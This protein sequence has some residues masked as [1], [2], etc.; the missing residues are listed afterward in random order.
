MTTTTTSKTAAAK[1]SKG[2]TD[3]ERAAMRARAQE[4]KEE[5]RRADGLEALLAA[6]AAMNEPDRTMGERV[7][8]VITATAPSL[9]PK[10]WYGMPAYTKDGK[11]LCF[12]RPA[13]KFGER[14]AMLGFNDS[15]KLDDGVMW[16]IAY[17]LE[18]VT[19]AEEAAIA[20]LV[21]QAAG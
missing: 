8:A 16:P 20:A 2:F 4:L 11:V 19:A 1:A 17:A 5:A 10:T 6:I 9:A 13:E 21:K 15:A 12:F 18:T 7:H 14:Y 3:A